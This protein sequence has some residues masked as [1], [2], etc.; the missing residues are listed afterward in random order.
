LDASEYHRIADAEDRHWWYRS[1]RRLARELLAGATATGIVS[2][3]VGAGPGGNGAWL[4][5]YGPVIA[6][7]VEPIAL[8]YVRTRRLELTPVRGS[9][10]ALPLADASVDVVLVLTVLYHVADDG[11]AMREAARVLRPGGHVLLLEPAFPFLRREHDELT[12]G[13]R[14]YRRADLERLA[15]RAGLDVTR[16]TY[17]KSY[18]FP[19]MALITMA[20]R[21]LG[22]VSKDREPRS[23]LRPRRLD[24]LANPIFE[25]LAAAEDRVLQRRDLPFGT[26]AVV[27]ARKRA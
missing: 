20:H 7:D 17:A 5:D 26:S 1:T 24:R 27:V 19:P 2:V 10:D 22:R 16:S 23:D 13:L 12:H 8:D 14:R 15:H 18:L 9:A 6:L 11:R 3:D 4:A 25:R 21:A